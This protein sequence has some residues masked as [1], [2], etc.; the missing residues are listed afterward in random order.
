MQSG[1]HLFSLSIDSISGS[2]QGAVSCEYWVLWYVTSTGLELFQL[3]S[4]DPEA[5]FHSSTN[6]AI[7]AIFILMSR[8]QKRNVL[9]LP[10]STR[11]HLLLL[12][13]NIAATYQTILKAKGLGHRQRQGVRT[14]GSIRL[15]PVDK[16]HMIGPPGNKL[17]REEYP[18]PQ[19]VFIVFLLP[20]L[21]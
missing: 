14:L 19:N 4:Q 2:G 6:D 1:Y 12:T 7:I 18:E 9:A 10:S 17:E 16:N 15:S 21:D 8:E 20:S 3:L 13:S 11:F 5:S